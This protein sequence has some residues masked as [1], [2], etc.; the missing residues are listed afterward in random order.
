MAE[1]GRKEKT[2]DLLEC[3]AEINVHDLACAA[4]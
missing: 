1:K 4:V 2:P 3:N